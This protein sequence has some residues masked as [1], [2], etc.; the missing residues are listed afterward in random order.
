MLNPSSRLKTV[1]SHPVMDPGTIIAVVE[2]SFSVLSL[3]AKYYSDVKKAKEDIE[4][5]KT[6]VEALY[7]VLRE[8][9]DLVQHSKIPFLASLATAI[10][11]S[12]S[13]IENIKTKL[14]ASERKKARS[15]IGLRALKW[16]FTKR[17]VEEHIAKLE[18]HKTTLAL[19]LNSGQT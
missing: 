10:Q 5:L 9:Q 4:H 12:L 8:I 6:E 13:D 2:T 14:D 3:I 16:P 11:D 17:E 19:A 18:K 15:C 7:N 1:V